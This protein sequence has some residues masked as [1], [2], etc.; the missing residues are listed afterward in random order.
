MNHKI[1]DFILKAEPPWV[2]W[3]VTTLHSIN[4]VTA[5]EGM[6]P[7]GTITIRWLRGQK[8]RTVDTLFS[9]IAAA[10][11]FPYYFGQNWNA[12]D[13]CIA[14]LEWIDARGYLLII[15]NADE[16]LVDTADPLEEFQHFLQKL[17]DAGKA[18]TQPDRDGPSFDRGTKPFHV[19]LHVVASKQSMFLDRLE[20]AGVN[21]PEISLDPKPGQADK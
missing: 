19:I 12:F 17:E 15:F 10:L 6:P 9:E 20:R 1:P 7:P 5:Q 11:Q 3:C 4:S 18:W 2:Y 8:M 16:V 14:D 21:L 13:E